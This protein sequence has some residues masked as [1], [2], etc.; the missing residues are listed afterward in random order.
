MLQFTSNCVVLVDW[1][2]QMPLVD[3]PLVAHGMEEQQLPDG[4]ALERS[5]PSRILNSKIQL[6]DSIR[7]LI[8]F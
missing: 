1:D 7:R 5:E 8:R 6:E 4:E 3:M 2:G